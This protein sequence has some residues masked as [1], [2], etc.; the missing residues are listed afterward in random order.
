MAPE[1]W[2]PLV[3]THVCG[4]THRDRETEKARDNQ[5]M[6]C[7]YPLTAEISLGGGGLS[8]RWGAKKKENL[9]RKKLEYTCK[10]LEWQGRKVSTL[11][12]MIVF[13]SLCDL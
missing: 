4:H 9:R 10:A 6:L 12:N 3:Y 2:Y 5:G 1:E 8:V 11:G 13:S 7:E